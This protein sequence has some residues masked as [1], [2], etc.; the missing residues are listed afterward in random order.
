[1]TRSESYQRQATLF[2]KM[3]LEAEPR[4]GAMYAELAR[5][6][7]DLA[8]HAAAAERAPEPRSWAP[9]AAGDTAESASSTVRLAAVDGQRAP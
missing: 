9:H 6:W 8:E 5:A 3:A 7:R 1:M 4:H 2:A